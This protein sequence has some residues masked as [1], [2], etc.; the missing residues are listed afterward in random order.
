MALMYEGVEF[1]GIEKRQDF[2]CNFRGLFTK[3]YF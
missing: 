2:K 1:Y 3:N